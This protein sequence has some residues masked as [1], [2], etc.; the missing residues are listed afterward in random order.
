MLYPQLLILCVL[1]IHFALHLSI[2][3]M[4]RGRRH[5]DPIQ[6]EP[7]TKRVV[8]YCVGD[9][10]QYVRLPFRKISQTLI[11]TWEE[12][13]RAHSLQNLD[14]FFITL[15]LFGLERITASTQYYTYRSPNGLTPIPA[16][17]LRQLLNFNFCQ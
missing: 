14:F 9:T 16:P 15:F 10:P 4:A 1:C 6:I 17:K 11:S 12:D 13:G 2:L 3:R 5:T 8:A 7:L